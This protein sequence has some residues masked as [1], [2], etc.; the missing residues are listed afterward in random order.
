M[1]QEEIS[2]ITIL[3]IRQ[4]DEDKVFLKHYTLGWVG[5]TFKVFKVE[6]HEII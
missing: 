5:A 6:M 1:G 3:V 2:F 4:R